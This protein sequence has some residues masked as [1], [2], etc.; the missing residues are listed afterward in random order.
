MELKKSPLG[1]QE[2]T[3]LGW[4]RTGNWMIRNLLMMRELL[5]AGNYLG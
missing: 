2:I 3:W 4:G 5:I 1:N